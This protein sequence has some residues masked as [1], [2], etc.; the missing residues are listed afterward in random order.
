MALSLIT[1]S[2]SYQFFFYNV[3]SLGIWKS[4]LEW[5]MFH[6]AFTRNLTQIGS[7][8]T[9]LL[10]YII[11]KVKIMQNIIFLYLLSTVLSFSLYNFSIFAKFISK[12]LSSQFYF[13]KYI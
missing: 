10:I 7:T 11:Q 5:F 1:I 6:S 13:W 12:L 3:I 2:F 9:S 4:N 8:A